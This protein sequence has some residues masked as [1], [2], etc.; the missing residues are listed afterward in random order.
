M[1]QRIFDCGQYTTVVTASCPLEISIWEHGVDGYELLNLKLEY[2]H[3]KDQD[4]IATVLSR[5]L[6]I[7]DAHRIE[8]W[9]VEEYFPY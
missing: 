2:R 6:P 8:S 3:N 5:F 7:R 4:F 9:I 1:E